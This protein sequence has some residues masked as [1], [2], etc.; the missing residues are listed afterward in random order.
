MKTLIVLLSVFAIA[1]VV[2]KIFNSSYEFAL[3]ARIAMSAMLLF[4]A[5]GH[6]VFTKGMSLMLPDFV[7]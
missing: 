2:N 6:F 4:T 1:I 7:P 3:S 5:V